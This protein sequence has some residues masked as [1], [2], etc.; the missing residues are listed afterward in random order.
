MSSIDELGSEFDGSDT[1]SAFSGRTSSPHRDSIMSDQRPT[2]VTMARARDKTPQNM[3]AMLDAQ[4]IEAK[5]SKDSKT[6]FEFAKACLTTGEPVIYTLLVV[7]NSC[8][9]S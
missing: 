9:V 2:F 8:I 1:A 4:R 5:N 3:A 6:Q 7:T